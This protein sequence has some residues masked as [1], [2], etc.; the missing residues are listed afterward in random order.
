[1]IVGFPPK[2]PWYSFWNWCLCAS[3]HSYLMLLQFP[4]CGNHFSIW[5]ERFP[6]S[7]RCPPS[8]DVLSP[9]R[10][11]IWF[12]IPAG[13]TLRTS[14][15]RSFTCLQIQSA[16]GLEA[17]TS[18]VIPHVCVRLHL[19]TWTSP[20]FFCRRAVTMKSHCCGDWGQ[21]KQNRILLAN[22]V[23]EGNPLA[24]S[25]GERYL[26]EM[27]IRVMVR[28]AMPSELFTVLWQNEL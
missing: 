15:I 24:V 19:M 28:C 6:R 3:G 17:L 27:G 20:V 25:P 7:T 16:L 23:A 26:L 8:H 13:V 10:S 1:M 18:N 11:F 2:C 9:N 12:L 5:V 21:T 14:L 22:F 4:H